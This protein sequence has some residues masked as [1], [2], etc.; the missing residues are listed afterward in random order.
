MARLIPLVVA[1]TTL[2]VAAC[3][4][5]T[6]PRLTGRWATKGLELTAST[7]RSDLRLPCAS[8]A[9]MPPLRLDEAGRF[10]LSGLASHTYGSFVIVLRGQVVHNTI[11]ADLTTIAEGAP[12]STTHYV[13]VRG[14][15]PAFEQFACLGSARV[16]AA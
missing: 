16:G 8:V 3:S 5:P 2:V 14:A 15:D 1:A 10:E 11:Q 6:A 7:R 12:P 13:L 4:D 9:S